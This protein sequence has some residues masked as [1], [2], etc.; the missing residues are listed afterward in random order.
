MK[1]YLL[2]I[3]A[4]TT[5]NYKVLEI[6]IQDREFTCRVLQFISV[7]KDGICLLQNKTLDGK[8]TESGHL[9][10]KKTGRRYLGGFERNRA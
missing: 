9:K 5:E 6:T 2:V 10:A 7:L 1:T 3:V 4:V 8:M